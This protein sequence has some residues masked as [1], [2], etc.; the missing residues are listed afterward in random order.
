MPKE[1]EDAPTSVVE[2]RIKAIENRIL[3]LEATSKRDTSAE[4][5]ELREKLAA[6]M[7]KVDPPKVEPVAVPVTTPA[8]VEKSVWDWF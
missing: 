8:P 3:D 7:K 6:L 2:A 1:N 4:V 5:A